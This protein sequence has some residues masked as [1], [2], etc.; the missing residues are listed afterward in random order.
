MRKP[1]A[2]PT[3]EPSE[4]LPSAIREW[5]RREPDRPFLLEV[6]GSSRSYG[7]LHEAALRWA[8]AFR[9]VGVAP[10]DNVPAMV[11]TSI[12]AQEQWLGLAWLRAAQTGGNTG[13]PGSSPA[14]ITA[15]SR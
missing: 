6:G 15:K 10:G 5:A 3:F 12:T 9:D 8:G 11:R 4:T 13:S 7:Q 14:R 2:E 1:R